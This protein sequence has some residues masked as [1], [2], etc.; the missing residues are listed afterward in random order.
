MENPFSLRV[1]DFPHDD[2]RSYMVTVYV[3][4]SAQGNL[5]LPALDGRDGGVQVHLDQSE[6]VRRRTGVVAG[7]PRDL[8]VPWR[9]WSLCGHRCGWHRAAV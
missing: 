1:K 4:Q 7:Y 2:S 5:A 3:L 6:R 8:S 9:V